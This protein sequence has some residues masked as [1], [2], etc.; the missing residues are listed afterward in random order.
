MKK[1]FVIAIAVMVAGLITVPAFAQNPCSGG[2]CVK[3]SW[4]LADP[5]QPYSGEVSLR[6]LAYLT[7]NNTEPGG[8]QGWAGVDSVE[9]RPNLR[10]NGAQLWFHEDG[11]W[12]G[13]CGKFSLLFPSREKLEQYCK[14]PVPA[15]AKLRAKAAAE[16]LCPSSVGKG[17]RW[18][19]F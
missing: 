19:S 2:D 11:R 8:S 10:S 18:H 15:P 4:N 16:K 1:Y 7:Y 3:Q 12:D 14:N 5:R 9:I 13:Q 6:A 17:Q